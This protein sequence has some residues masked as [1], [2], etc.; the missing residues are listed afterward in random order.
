MS[1]LRLPRLSYKP[2]TRDPY[3]AHH[4]EE[5]LNGRNL[6]RGSGLYIRW[7]CK[8]LFCCWIAPVHRREWCKDTPQAQLPWSIP[9]SRPLNL[10]EHEMGGASSAGEPLPPVR[11]ELR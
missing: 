3:T 7:Y 4:A 8:M 5:D 11:P 1:P 6:D 10:A 9:P 2:L